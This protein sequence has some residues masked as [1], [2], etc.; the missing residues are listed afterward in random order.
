MAIVY[1]LYKMSAPGFELSTIYDSVVFE[2]LVAYT[3]HDCQKILS[4][5]VDDP[6]AEL[7]GTSCGAEFI[8][9]IID[10]SNTENEEEH[11]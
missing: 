9:E 5:T 2:T 8:L 6:I 11:Y 1:K 4:A 10:T 7:L 3:C